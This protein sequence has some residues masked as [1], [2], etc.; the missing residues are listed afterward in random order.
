MSPDAVLFVG[1]TGKDQEA[2]IISNTRFI[3]IENQLAIFEKG[4]GGL[5]KDMK[6]ALLLLRGAP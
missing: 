4:Y 1:D 2:A 5:V 3:G 6:Q